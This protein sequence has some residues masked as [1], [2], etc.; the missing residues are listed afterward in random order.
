VIIILTQ[1]CVKVGGLPFTL[2]VV[3]CVIVAYIAIEAYKWG[4]GKY[5]HSMCQQ[6]QSG[7]CLT[8]CGCMDFCMRYGSISV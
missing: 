5:V 7:K 2:S 3:M 8:D 6:V 4:M 1:H